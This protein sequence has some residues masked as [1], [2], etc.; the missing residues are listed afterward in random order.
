MKNIE[1]IIPAAE[2]AYESQFVPKLKIETQRM[3][4]DVIMRDVD[5]LDGVRAYYQN[6]AVK[7]VDAMQS[8]MPQGLVDAIFGVLAQRLATTFMISKDSAMAPPA[9]KT[10]RKENEDGN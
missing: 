6:W 5:G 10:T 8:A 1:L 7:I 2:P 4:L 3:H 9:S